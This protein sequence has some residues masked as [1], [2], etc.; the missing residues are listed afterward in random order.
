[1][2]AKIEV[3]G[4][5]SSDLTYSDRIKLAQYEELIR[6]LFY[7]CE[8]CDGPLVQ[9]ATCLDCKKTAMR[10]CIGCNTVV[11]IPHGS[12]TASSTRYST[13]SFLGVKN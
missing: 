8:K 1:M 10:I 6:K 4:G 9:L 3:E 13:K 5:Q 7:A 12:C 11:R 2:N